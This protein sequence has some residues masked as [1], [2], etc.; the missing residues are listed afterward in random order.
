MNHWDDIRRKARAQ[1]TIVCAAA[2]GN[3]SATTLLDAAAHITDIQSVP[4]P[5]G[6][7]LLDGGEAVLD[8]EV[9]IIWYNADLES[10]LAAFYIAH[11]YA[12]FWLDGE[13][14]TCTQSDIDAETS[15]ECAPIGVQRVEGYSPE[16]RR[17]REANVF[18]REFLLPADILQQWYVTDGLHAREIAARVGALEGMV[19]HQLARSLL[20]PVVPDGTQID[21]SAMGLLDL[22]LS[23]QEAAYAEQGPLLVEAGPG[24]GKT[25]T[26]VGRIAFLL[27]KG[28]EPSAILALTFSNRAAEE[29]RSRFGFVAPDAAR[30]IWMGTFHAFGLEL[31]RKFGTRLGLP[32]RVSVIDPVDALFLLERVLPSLQLDYY[33]NL[34]EPTMYLRDI[35]AAISRA[36]DELISPTDYTALA[37]RMR[38]NAVTRE[39]VEAAEKALEVA[40]VYTLYQDY[41]DQKHLL[42]FGDLIFK[43]IILLRSCADIRTQVQRTY[44]HI[45]IDEYQDVNR[46]SGLLLC[47]IAGAGLWVVGDIRQAIYRWR[48]AAP[49]NMRLFSKDFPGAMVQTLRRNYRSQPVIVDVFATLAP[50][51]RAT[52]GVSFTSWEPYR[53][54]AGGKVLLEIA[55][56][57]AAEGAGI[58]R[59]IAQ[60]QAVGIPYRDQAVLCRSHTVLA[61]IAAQLEIAGIPI[62]YLGNLFERPEIRDLLSLLSLACEADGRGLIRVARFVEYQIP[63]ADVI[64]LL[65]L[66]QD[67]NVPFPRALKLAKDAERISQRGKRGFALLDQHLDGLCYGTSAWSLLGRYLFDRSRYLH[68]TLRDA[69]VAGQQERMAIFQFL[70]FAHE[71][72]KA[73]SGDGADP[74]RAFLRYVRR[75]AVF[76]ED[77]QLRQLP[78]WATSLDAVRLLTIHASKGLEFDVVYLPGLNQGH[79]PARRQWQPCPPPIGMLA[80]D[81]QDDHEE[82]EE[83]LFFVALSRARNFLYLSHSRRYGSRNSNA[84]SLLSLV[85]SQFPRSG[86]NAATWSS[87]RV[88]AQETQ[89]PPAVPLQPASSV[90]DVEMLDLY[91][92]CPRQYYYEFVLGLHGRRE[93]SAYMQFHSCVYDVIRWLQQEQAQGREV[94]EDAAQAGLIASWEMKGPR[95]HPYEKIYRQNAEAMVTRA[96]SRLLQLRGKAIRPNWEIPLK[97]GRVRFTPDSVEVIEDNTGPSLTV[98]RLRTG[99]P[100]QSERDK[101]I[102]ALYQVGAKQAYPAAERKVELVYL[103]TDQIDEIDLGPKKIATRLERYDAAIAGILRQE[104]PALPDDRECPRCPYYFICPIADDR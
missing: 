27:D 72:R 93:D 16:E 38:A 10:E 56:D 52:Q 96:L 44:T 24:T 14:A 97:H 68:T 85:E 69:S 23:Q 103:S 37:E 51:M 71:Q 33:Q 32:A 78:E 53:L 102:Y 86:N 54:D 67:Q 11:E 79:F 65:S 40:R 63:F 64:A 75:L 47:E 48:G 77:R 88:A 7:S 5:A 73:M 28:V 35:L 99:R 41:L 46:A 18:A 84:S 94:D 25:R 82:E 2:N 98:R 6:D 55:E 62:L 80:H 50:Q 36:K 60:H 17:E 34:Y 39:E 100:S 13:Y 45:L 70:Q 81:P 87:E 104:F 8:R 9:G 19:L 29:M 91:N 1:H 101:D 42:D 76:G 3:P 4:V 12:H 66:A 26:L 90:F 31:L 21:G 30:R 59:K 95:D 15:E 89:G 20:I 43:A 57:P 92:R 22:D 61:R 74:K 83:C 58:A 49:S